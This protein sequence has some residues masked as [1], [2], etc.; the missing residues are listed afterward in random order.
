MLS[1]LFENATGFDAVFNAESINYGCKAAILKHLHE[2]GEFE[3]DDYVKYEMSFEEAYNLVTEEENQ[4]LTESVE[5][6]NVNLLESAMPYALFHF[7]QEQGYSKDESKVIAAYLYESMWSKNVGSALKKDWEKTKERQGKR[8]QAVKKGAKKVGQFIKK[9]WQK[10]GLD[11]KDKERIRKLKERLKSASGQAAERI[12]K[13][14]ARIQ[15]YYNKNSKVVRAVKA[16]A[17]A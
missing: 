8:N 11:P 5:G 2:A 9:D 17:K 16:A 13:D 6:E 10:S 12:K 15:G 3:C 7:V 4:I 14:I 1:Q